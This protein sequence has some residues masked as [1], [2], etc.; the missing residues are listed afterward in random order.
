MKASRLLW[1]VAVLLI[2]C[3]VVFFIIRAAYRRPYREEVAAGGIPSALV[4]AVMK[5]ESGFREDALSHAGAVGLMQVKP[6]TAEFI[7]ARRGVVF[8]AERLQEG[9]YNVRVGCMY[10]AYLL[11]RFPHK[12]TALAAYNA[13]EGRVRQWLADEALSEDG[14]VLKAIPYP[15][16][17]T[18]V[19][20]VLKFEKFYEFFYG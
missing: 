4:Y 16:T 17:R 19:K 15:E 18:Y 10:L 2:A 9:G 5:A 11:E 1:I 20:K 13:G 12:E 8:A 14:N 3:V 7:C 6:A